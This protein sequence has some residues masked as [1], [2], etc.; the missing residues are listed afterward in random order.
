M[1]LIFWLILGVAIGYLGNL[2]LSA[3]PDRGCFLNVFLGTLGA[4]A[5]GSLMASHVRAAATRSALSLETLLAC[6]VALLVA[7]ALVG[8]SNLLRRGRLR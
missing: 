1:T 3:E 5:A 8:L 2:V 6:V 7:M 4:L